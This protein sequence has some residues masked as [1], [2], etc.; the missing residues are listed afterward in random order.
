MPYV[1]RHGRV[2]Q[3]AQ[4]S[5]PLLSDKQRSIAVLIA[6]LVLPSMGLRAYKAYR[7]E[8]KVD[9]SRF[10]VSAKP[11]DTPAIEKMDGVIRVEFC[12]S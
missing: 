2:Q 7:S 1:D 8:Q 9:L 6:A 5:K 12:T 10:A 3:G 4:P 11:F